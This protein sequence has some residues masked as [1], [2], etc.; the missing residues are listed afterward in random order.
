MATMDPSEDE[1]SQV[2]D[3]AGLNHVDDR[4][5]VINALKNNNRNVETVVMQF[6]DGPENFRQKYLKAWNEELFGADREGNANSSGISFHIESVNQNDIIQGVTPPPPDYA[7]GAPSRPPS[8]SNDR[9]PLGRVVDWAASDATGGAPLRS[10]EDEDIQRALRESAYEAGISFSSPLETGVTEASTSTPYFGPANRSDYD[11]GSW[12]MVPVGPAAAKMSDIPAP[13]L[14]KRVAGAPAFLIQGNTSV[15]NHRLGGLLTILH[16]IPLARNILLNCGAPAATYGYNNEWWKGQ[17]ILSTQALQ[18]LQSGEAQWGEQGEARSDFEEEIHRLMAFLDSTERS[19]GTVSVLTDLTQDAIN[20]PEKQFY[21]QLGHQYEK[22]FEPL[23]QVATLASVYGDD[24]G[25]EDARFGL[26]ELEPPKSDY[27]TITTLYESIDHLMWSDAFAWN[28]VHESSRM[29]MLKN[30]GEV[31]AI[32][33]GGDGPDDSLEIPME[34]YPEKYLVS[35][36]DEARRI[37]LGWCE[38]K[39]AMDRL[40]KEEKS[41]QTWQND[42]KQEMSDK[43]GMINRARDQWKA[44]SDYLEGYGR[45][46]TMEAAGFDTN[47]YP[48]YRAASCQMTE[49]QQKYNGQ[50]EEVLLLAERVLSDVE[51]RAKDLRAQLEQIKA[52]QRFL[53]RLLTNPDKPGRSK[54]MT[55]KKYLLRGV[56][57]EADVVYVCQR[58]ERDLIDLGD[59]QKHLDQ[60]WRLAYAPTDSQQPVKSEKVEVERVLREMWQETKTPLLVYATEESLNTLREPLVDSLDRFV[61]SENRAFRIELSQESSRSSEERGRPAVDPISPSKR[62]HRADSMDSMNSNRAS[63]GSD[64]RNPFENPFGDRMES[65]GVEL[66]D[67]SNG[68]KSEVGRS[69]DAENHSREAS[70]PPLIPSRELG[71]LGSE[72]ATLTPDTLTAEESEAVRALPF[73]VHQSGDESRATEFENFDTKA[74]E[75]Q[76]RARPLTFMATAGKTSDQERQDSNMDMEIP[77]H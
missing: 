11:Q 10:Q 12:A 71:Y 73:E 9:S 5:M 2:I 60:W 25:S 40:L 6:F 62:K 56:A 49:D 36:K 42:L 45:F 30:M 61:R 26:L 75:M 1:I 47:K 17:Q 76:E 55:C 51:T 3:F 50:V 44:F 63:L 46:Q 33:F 4:I 24:Q 65:I 32:K 58:L 59:N 16:E 74:P 66:A 37:Q 35:R 7:A 70:L 67:L 43:N 77:D 8:R 28:E 41:L 14:R 27:A 19:Y 31:L 39:T 69:F 34:L 72:S 20:G 68:S 64:D 13:S 18:K 22:L 54:P 29:A 38:T 48:D 15:G 52:K 53:G 21:E 23:C 57:T